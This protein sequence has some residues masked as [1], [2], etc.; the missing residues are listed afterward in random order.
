MALEQSEKFA[1][2]L[3]SQEATKLRNSL[4]MIVEHFDEK[5]APVL[6]NKESVTLETTKLRDLLT[7]AVEHFD[8]KIA[9]VLRKNGDPALSSASHRATN[10]CGKSRE[11]MQIFSR[12][13]FYSFDY[14]EKLPSLV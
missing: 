4:T 10:L 1:P 8:Q 3:A 2:L 7:K 5:I 12:D 14:D 6:Q 13:F 11:K 9:P